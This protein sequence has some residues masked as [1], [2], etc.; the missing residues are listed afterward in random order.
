MFNI[1][2]TPTHGGVEWTPATLISPDFGP[3]RKQ[4]QQMSK[5]ELC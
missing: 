1:V 3:V 2:R 4:D 5:R